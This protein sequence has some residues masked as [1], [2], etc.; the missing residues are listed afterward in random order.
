[1]QLTIGFDIDSTINKAHYF[2]IIHGRE[3]C[4]EY[5]YHHGED[6][7]KQSVKDMFSFNDDLYNKYMVKFFP[8]NVQN[9]VPVIGAPQIMRQLSNEGHKIVIVTAR[10]ENYD[11][12]DSPYKGWMMTRDTIEWLT[13]YR[14]PYNDIIFSAKDK[15]EVCD[16][17]GIDILIDDSPTHI[18]QCKNKKVI[19]IVMGQSYNQMYIN[20]PGCIYVN[21]FFELKEQLDLLDKLYERPTDFL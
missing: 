21:N 6:L 8:W 10:D 14:I 3:L 5:N 1:M 7:S 12:E 13:K 17:N 4:E 11:K 9:N 15:G 2:D 20:T 16:K 19:P 18:E